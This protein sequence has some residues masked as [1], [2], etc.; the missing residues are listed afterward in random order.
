MMNGVCSS[1]QGSLVSR[2]GGAA[3]GAAAVHGPSAAS[4][5]ASRGAARSKSFG[6]HP[7]STSASLTSRR[8]FALQAL[9]A[10]WG[11]GPKVKRVSRHRQ[12]PGAFAGIR[13]RQEPPSRSPVG[14][15]GNRMAKPDKGGFRDAFAA[16]EGV[17]V[18]EE[19]EAQHPSV[20]DELE[21]TGG[22]PPRTMGVRGD[23]LS[24]YRVLVLDVSMKA[25]DIISWQRAFCLEIFE[26]VDCLE[27]YDDA[28]A[29]SAY[30]AYL[31]P[32][33]I[34]VRYYH[35]KNKKDGNARVSLNR[36]N[37]MIRD[38]FM[39]QYCGSDNNLTLDHVHPASKG[40]PRSWENLATACSPCNTRKG[41]KMLKSI[42]S[43]KLKSVPREPSL[44]QLSRYNKLGVYTNP[45]A[46]WR[47]YIPAEMIREIRDTPTTVTKL[48]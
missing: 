29:Y 45:P 11:A 1:P 31:I 36:R 12:A 47:P 26:K 3:A 39:C 48:A 20:E 17:L 23:D 7:S 37:I 34:K 28:L 14:T 10:S 40:G 16:E 21:M 2:G 18:Q 5:A 46:E 30:A 8:A 33:V 35:K 19:M 9:G 38:N 6:F 25:I 41:D 22:P 32:A 44:M 24:K 4:A 15:A 27:Y 43:M 42:P 13:V